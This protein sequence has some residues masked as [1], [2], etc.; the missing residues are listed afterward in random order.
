MNQEPGLIC[1]TNAYAD[2]MSGAVLLDVR[3]KDEV[4]AL[5][6]DVPEWIHLPF[7]ELTQRWRELPTDRDVLVVCQNGTQSAEAAL[8]LQRMGLSRV[9]PV[10]GGLLLW[11]QK[12][13]P[14]KGQRM[15]TAP[16][17]HPSSAS[18]YPTGKT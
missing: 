1:T 14:V 2:A 13:Y 3:K 15:D 4:Q 11:M 5:A 12:G 10:R 8:Y 6:F 18:P 9:K 7:S 16:L 17:S